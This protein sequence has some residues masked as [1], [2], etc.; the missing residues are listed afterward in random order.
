MNSNHYFITLN[1][2]IKQTFFTKSDYDFVNTFAAINHKDFKSLRE[3]LYGDRTFL[4]YLEEKYYQIR[5]KKL[6]ILKYESWNQLLYYILRILKPEILVET[7]VFDGITTSFLL[8]ALE[9]NDRGHLYS[10]DLPAYETKKGSTH[11]MKFTTLPRACD[12]GWI[13]PST[14]KQR[15]TLQKGSSNSL[16]KPLLEKLDHVDFFLHDSLHTYENMFYEYETVWPYLCDGGILGSDDILWNP[17]FHDFSIKVNKN[18]LGKYRF[19][20]LKK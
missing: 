16:L 19:G 9:K 7:G 5:R 4:N 2:I 20:V 15:W 14:L 3:E 1:E 12:V 8:K 10:I 11:R 13:I 17:S 6:S 18:Y